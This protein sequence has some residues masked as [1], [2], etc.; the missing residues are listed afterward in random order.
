MSV[1]WIW[2][3]ASKEQ[4]HI[5]VI[6][7]QDTGVHPAGAHSLTHTPPLGS[8]P[9]S[10]LTLAGT[11]PCLLTHSS[12]WSKVLYEEAYR[13]RKGGRNGDLSPEELNPA[14][15]T[16]VSKEADRSQSSFEMPAALW[17]TLSEG[18]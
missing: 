1:T 14:N 7:L 11:L 6:R 18:S 4:K 16:W 13:A 3:L 5:K 10:L 12:W 8:I 2:G 15:N 9:D 17:V